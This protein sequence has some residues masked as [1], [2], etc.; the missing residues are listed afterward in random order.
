[1][2]RTA[3][4][5]LWLMVVLRFG[6]CVVSGS[7]RAWSKKSLLRRPL[8]RLSSLSCRCHPPPLMLQFRYLRRLLAAPHAKPP[9]ADNYA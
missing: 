4:V 5:A 2:Q 9:F 1:M 7:R 8:P 3:N 6:H